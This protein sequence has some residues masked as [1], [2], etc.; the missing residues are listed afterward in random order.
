MTPIRG[1]QDTS[2]W[3]WIAAGVAVAAIVVALVWSARTSTPP[4]QRVAVTLPA[5]RTVP[6]PPDPAMASLAAF[7][8]ATRAREDGSHPTALPPMDRGHAS[9]AEGLRRLAAALDSFGNVPADRTAATLRANAALLET[10]PRS[11]RHADIV[12]D[13][14]ALVATFVTHADPEAGATLRRTAAGIDRNRPL[15]QQRAAVE[16]AFVAAADAVSRLS[17]SA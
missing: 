5:P 9:T 2:P 16:R 14:M 4:P 11:L 6:S 10:D 12:A 13:S 3:P 8:R 1:R 15:L 7:A 17:G